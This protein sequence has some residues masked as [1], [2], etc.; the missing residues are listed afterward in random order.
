MEMSLVPI[1]I[2]LLQ[3]NLI[4][5]LF[6]ECTLFTEILCE[7]IL[8]FWKIQ[9]LNFTS[10][11][12]WDKINTVGVDADKQKLKGPCEHVS[13]TVSGSY[14]SLTLISKYI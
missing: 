12:M 9:M 8:F 7:W 5:S 11:L 4:S 13:L 3:Y 10:R 14:C 2:V 1:K 6:G